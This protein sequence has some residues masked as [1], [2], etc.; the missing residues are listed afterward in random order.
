VEG[1]AVLPLSR[2]QSRS[3]GDWFKSCAGAEVNSAYAGVA[4][5]SAGEHGDAV[6]A[7]E[8]QRHA[9]VALQRLTDRIAGERPQQL[10]ARLLIRCWDLVVG[11][12]D[13]G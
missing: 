2:Q 4:V 3:R 7:L 9:D 13:H 8:G 12:L 10:P 6:A 11:E 1:A 5:A